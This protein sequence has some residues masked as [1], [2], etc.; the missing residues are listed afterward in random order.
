M[1]FVP[2]D[3][4]IEHVDTDAAGVVHFSRYLSL[5]ETAVLENLDRLGVGLSALQGTGRALV[6]AE[7]RMRYH[8]SAR[9]LDQVRV[10]AAVSHL[11][12]ASFRMSGTVN[13]PHGPLTTG[14]LVFAVTDAEG[15][16]AGLPDRLAT[17]LKELLP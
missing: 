5:L 8:A 11:G 13:G 4:R 16:P 12:P 2:V 1:T 10:E 6:V 17:A 3:R 15:A 7:S 9:F 14:T